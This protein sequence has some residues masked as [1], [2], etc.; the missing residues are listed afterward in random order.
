MPGLAELFKGA[1]FRTGAFVGAF[2]L[3]RRFGLG[4]GFDVYGDRMPR[5]AGA[6]ANERPGWMVVDEALSWLKAADAGHFFV[7]VHLFEPHAPYGR[8]GDSRK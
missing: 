6:A 5:I 2:P 4:R 7:W 1:G 3:D 8:P